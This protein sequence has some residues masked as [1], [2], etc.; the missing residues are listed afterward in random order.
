MK[1]GDKYTLTRVVTDNETAGFLG[2]GGLPVYATPAMICHMELASY[3]LAEQHGFQT[4]GT[5]VN[6]SHLKACLAGT[7]VT[8][9]AELTEI[10][11]RRLE[12]DIKVECKDGLVGEGT[13]QRFVIDPERFMS[14]LK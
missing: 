6:I 10:D 4:V 11:G 13:H 9:T 8:V 3:K 2:S 5:K 14:K 12:Y 7:E 1:T